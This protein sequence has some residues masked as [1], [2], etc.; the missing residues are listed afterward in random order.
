MRLDLTNQKF[1]RL[2]VIEFAGI[3]KNQNSLWSCLCECGIFKISLGTEIK[4]GTIKSCGCF[5]ESVLVKNHRIKHGHSRRGKMTQTYRSWADMLKRCNNKNSWAYK[6]YG[7]RG[8]KVCK[9]WFKYENFLEDMG[10]RSSKLTL[11]RKDNDKGY[12]L[13]NCRWATRKQQSQNRRPFGKNRTI[14]L[15]T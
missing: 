7:G 3:N 14:P 9:R 15:S 5:R 4:K 13:S 2:I 1:N 8:I 11:D 12:E 10:I 6:Y